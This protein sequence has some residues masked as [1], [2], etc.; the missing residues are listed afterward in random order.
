[1]LNIPLMA[2]AVIVYYF[3][4]YVFITDLSA[5]LAH[6][7]LQAGHMGER[8]QWVI[9]FIQCLHGLNYIHEYLASRSRLRGL[10]TRSPET[11]SPETRSVR[12]QWPLVV[13]F[14]PV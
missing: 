4:C 6:L 3:L 2:A 13:L 1:M 5:R 12:Q 8:V 9:Y 10:E 14:V 7:M 11:R